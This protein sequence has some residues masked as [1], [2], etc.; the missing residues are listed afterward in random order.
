MTFVW[1]FKNVC[2]RSKRPWYDLKPSVPAR[3]IVW[4]CN[5]W[6]VAGLGTPYGR[7]CI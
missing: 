6:H 7:G 4:T 2:L 1:Y 5:F 3:C